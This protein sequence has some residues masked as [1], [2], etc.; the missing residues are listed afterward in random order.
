M[1]RR[2][3][4]CLALLAF[5]WAGPMQAE[6]SAAEDAPTMTKIRVIL[7]DATLTATL[8]DTAA[9][10]SFAALLPLDLTLE[11]YHGIEKISDLPGKLD[12]TGA[13]R[14]YKPETGDITLYAPWG[15][16]AIF[17][18]PFSSSAGLVR[19]GAFEG[20]IAPLKKSGALS[21]RFELAE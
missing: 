13:P 9:G 10:R 6:P 4:L 15:N 11:D 12:T 7:P 3:F 18:K 14:A 8:D 21:A 17:I 20:T 16:L 1:Y 19:L 2:A 5:G